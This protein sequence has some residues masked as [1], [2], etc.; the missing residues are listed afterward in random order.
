MCAM[1]CILAY[2]LHIYI[3]EWNCARCMGQCTELWFPTFTSMFL[4]PGSQLFALFWNRT[5][6]F[7]AHVRKSTHAIKEL[8]SLQKQQVRKDTPQGEPLITDPKVDESD[9]NK[10]E[11]EGGHVQ[12]EDRLTSVLALRAPLDTRWNSLCFMIKR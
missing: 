6:A 4:H 3:E 10:G 5:K 12:E 11:A 7:V 1:S 2:T 8:R 9:E